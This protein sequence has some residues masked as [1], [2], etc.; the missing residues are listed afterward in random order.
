MPER[1]APEARELL[2]AFAEWA[3]A[4][5]QAAL[6][7]DDDWTWSHMVDAF[8]LECSMNG[9]LADGDPEAPVS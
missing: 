6:L 3:S 9:D 1:L 5:R 2:L 7:A 8:L 4:P